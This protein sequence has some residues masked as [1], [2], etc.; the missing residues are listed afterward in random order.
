MVRVRTLQHD[1]D[2]FLGRLSEVTRMSSLT[3]LSDSSVRQNP[4]MAWLPTYNG[5]DVSPGLIIFESSL[6]FRLSII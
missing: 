1:I 5:T 2:L 6:F 4:S 3:S